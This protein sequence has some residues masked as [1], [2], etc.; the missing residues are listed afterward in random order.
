MTQVLEGEH[1]TVTTIWPATVRK[2]L[3]ENGIVSSTG[4]VHKYKRKI[5]LKAFTLAALDSYVPRIRRGTEINV[6][7]TSYGFSTRDGR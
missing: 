2:L 7:V 3:G 6:S 5:A 1:E 4:S